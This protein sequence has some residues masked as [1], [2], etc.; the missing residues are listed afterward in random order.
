MQYLEAFS[1]AAVILALPSTAQAPTTARQPTTAT[2]DDEDEDDLLYRGVTVGHPGYGDAL[3]G[4]AQPRGG[5][6]TS[7]EHNEGF[8]DSIYTSWSHSFSTASWYAN[9]SGQGGV[10]L[11]S[12]IPRSRQTPSPDRFNE[13]EVLVRG[14]VIGANVTLIKPK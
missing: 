10:V 8:T 6:S 2:T 13:G 5:T 1:L 3:L 11:T 7:E 12:R 4:T 14:I 9:R